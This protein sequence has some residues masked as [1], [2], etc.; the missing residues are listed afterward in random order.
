MI[1]EMRK[2]QLHY[3]W[4]VGLSHLKFKQSEDI[5]QEWLTTP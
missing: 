3:N 2:H 4:G 1:W 5:L